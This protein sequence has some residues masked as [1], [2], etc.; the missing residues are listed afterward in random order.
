MPGY[1]INDYFEIKN[2]ERFPEMLVEVYGRWGDQ[3]FSTV[4]YDSGSQWDGTSKGKEAPVGTYYYILI[5]YP[6]AK[7]ISGNVTIIR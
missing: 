6:G 5:P 3:Y 2:A 4:G 1:G 7:P